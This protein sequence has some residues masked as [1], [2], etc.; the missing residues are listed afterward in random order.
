MSTVKAILVSPAGDITEINIKADY[1]RE[2]APK[3][4]GQDFHTSVTVNADKGIL[5]KCGDYPR[6]EYNEKVFELT[7]H[8]AY[9]N[10]LFYRC[11]KEGNKINFTFNQFEK[12]VNHKINLL[13][14]ERELALWIETQTKNYLLNVEE[15]TDL[16]RRAKWEDFIEKHKKHYSK[17]WR[18]MQ[19][20]SRTVS[21]TRYLDDMTL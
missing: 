1:D 16:S 15:M 10:V 18:A 20:Y 5:F 4:F 12:Q 11:N 6:G 8:K 2:F 14:K 21:Q 9:G 7:E 3:Y 13:R 17:E 19:E